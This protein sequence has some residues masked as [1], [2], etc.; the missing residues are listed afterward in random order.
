MKIETN[1]PGH[2]NIVVE[3]EYNSEEHAIMDGYSYLGKSKENKDIYYHITKD[4]FTYA[5]I[6]GWE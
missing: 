3:A 6:T 5:L 2:E 1:I 4:G